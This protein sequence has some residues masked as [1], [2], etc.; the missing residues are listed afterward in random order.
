MASVAYRFSLQQ[1]ALLPNRSVPEHTSRAYGQFGF[2]LLGVCVYSSLLQVA[3]QLTAVD[4]A[5]FPFLLRAV[6]TTTASFAAPS[7]AN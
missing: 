7:A 6:T 3:G 4:P 1:V 2:R 5:L